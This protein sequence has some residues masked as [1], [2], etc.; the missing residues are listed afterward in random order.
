MTS[1]APAQW[2]RIREATDLLGVSTATLRRWADAGHIHSF[3]T[4]GGHRRFDRSEVLAMIPTR[5][6]RTRRH[7]GATDASPVSGHPSREGREALRAEGQRIVA[8]LLS[9]LHAGDRDQQRALDR[10]LALAAGWGSVPGSAQLSTSDAVEI[11]H[12]LRGPFLREVAAGACHRGL[13]PAQTSRELIAAT[14]TMDRLLETC[15]ASHEAA[16]S[17][18]R[19]RPAP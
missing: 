5:H 6:S 19:H 12:R 15:I 4:P 7:R 16:R 18:A 17:E 1:S 3:T 9:S 11:L 13:S 8:I 2:L 14:R 10:A